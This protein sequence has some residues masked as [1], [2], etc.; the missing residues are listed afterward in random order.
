MAFV[1]VAGASVV[2]GAMAADASRSAAN[3]QADSV[4]ASNA[5][6]QAQFNQNQANLQAQQ[7]QLAPWVTSGQNA[8]QGMNQFMGLGTG[9]GVGGTGT[10][11]GVSQFQYN[12]AND[13]LN[14]FMLSQGS[15]AIANQASALGGVNSGK[16]L[17]DLSNYGQSTALSS[18]QTEFNNW[19]TSLNNIYNRL[20]GVSSQGQ[21]AAAGQA[22]IAQ[23]V[24]SLGA[25][26]AA[27]QGAATIGAGNAQAAATVAGSNSLTGSLNGIANSPQFQN[28]LTGLGQTTPS[29]AP[30]DLSQVGMGTAQQAPY[31][32]GYSPATGYAPSFGAP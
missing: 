13:P 18:Y 1:V 19:N 12:P 25:T 27:N 24:A 8:L 30:I 16:T 20:A 26:S 6:Q 28:W 15:Q 7:A 10:A 22:N 2:G 3:T 29:Y 32:A 14:Q 31:V 23:N 21:N 9:T 4:A 17:Q 5:Q 11:P